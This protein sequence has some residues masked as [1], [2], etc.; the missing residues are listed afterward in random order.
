MRWLLANEVDNGI[1]SPNHPLS[2]SIL[3]HIWVAKT[4]FFLSFFVLFLK[5]FRHIRPISAYL[6]LLREVFEGLGDWLF[7]ATEDTEAS[8]P[9]FREIVSVLSVNSVAVIHA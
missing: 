1:P 8:E 7:L 6:P 3:L 5:I 2:L 4:S 9:Y